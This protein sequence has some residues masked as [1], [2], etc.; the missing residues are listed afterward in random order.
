MLPKLLLSCLLISSISARVHEFTVKSIRNFRLPISTFG[1]YKDGVFNATIKLTRKDAPLNAGNPPIGFTFDRSLTVGGIKR[2]EQEEDLMDELE[3]V[4]QYLPCILDLREAMVIQKL[5]DMEM[6]DPIDR[7][8]F[9]I[10]F[11]SGDNNEPI[12]EVWKTPFF[13][14]GVEVYNRAGNG[15]I[16]STPLS[17]QS[18]NPGYNRSVNEPVP[19]NNKDATLEYTAKEA[20]NLGYTVTT[21][22]LKF[23]SDG[24]GGENQRELEIKFKVRVVEDTRGGIYELNFHDCYNRNE[25]INDHEDERPN[26]DMQ[27]EVYESNLNS[28]WL[29]LGVED[30]RKYLHNSSLKKAVIILI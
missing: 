26:F 1:Y 17:F 22:P 12:M 19:A 24:K 13:K 21:Y 18:F 25:L 16:R 6:K 3:P 23:E 10:T 4:N 14:E 9:K 15:F 2:M 30:V 27:I 5:T 29:G 7:I 8:T 20:M 28:Y 11:D